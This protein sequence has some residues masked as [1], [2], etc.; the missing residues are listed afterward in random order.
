MN[1]RY[2]CR[3]L[4]CAALVLVPL[5]GARAQSDPDA[6]TTALINVRAGPG[7]G[8]AVLSQFQPET[9]LAVLARSPD[10]GWLLAVAVDRGVRGWV[11]SGYVTFRAGF[12]VDRLPV[13]DA[14]LDETAA[15]LPPETLPQYEIVAMYGTGDVVRTLA[16]RIDLDAYPLIPEATATARRIYR[17]GQARGRDPH[18]IAKVGDCNS[19]GYVFLHP[20]GE[21]RYELGD[22]SALQPVID[23]FGASFTVLTRAAHNGMNAA[24]VLDPLWANPNACQPGESPLACEYRLHNPA[25]AVIMFGTNDLLA[26]DAEQFDRSLRRVA[27][28]TMQAGI[29]PILSTFPRHLALPERSILYNQIVVRVAHDYNLPLINLWRALEPLPDHGIAAD[30]FHLSGPLTGAGDFAT[31]ANL[32]TGFPLRNLLTLQALDAVWRGVTGGAPTP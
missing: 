7:T 24:A 28:E 13:S 4:I 22:Y 14:P 3:L 18:A 12:A 1:T 23:H 9:A 29:V 17:Q 8:Y 25:F 2:L 32:R 15:A 16:A 11:A 21:G 5:A 6:W 30:G 27:V 10:Y 31:P 19:V 26:L 20:F